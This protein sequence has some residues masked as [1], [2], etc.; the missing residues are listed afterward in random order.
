M[1]CV[2]LGRNREFFFLGGGG[3]GGVGETTVDCFMHNVSQ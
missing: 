1:H 3:G 2:F